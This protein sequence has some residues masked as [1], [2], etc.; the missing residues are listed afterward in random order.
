V[1]NARRAHVSQHG[2]S[3]APLPHARLGFAADVLIL[4]V[5]VVLMVLLLLLIRMLLVLLVLLMLKDV[6]N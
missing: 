2:K 4:L 3:P 5:M 6:S 1:Q